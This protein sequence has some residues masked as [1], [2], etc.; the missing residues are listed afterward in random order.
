MSDQASGLVIEENAQAVEA[1]PLSSPVALAVS[2][3]VASPEQEQGDAVPH[4]RRRRRHKT[5]QHSAGDGAGASRV[6]ADVRPTVVTFS[7]ELSLWVAIDAN[8][9]EALLSWLRTHKKLLEGEPLYNEEG[10]TPLYRMLQEGFFEGAEYLVEAVAADL[11]TQENRDGSSAL[12]WLFDKSADKTD[13]SGNKK[14]NLLFQVWYAQDRFVL[15]DELTQKA[16]ECGLLAKAGEQAGA[17][18]P[19]PKA[20]KRQPAK[21]DESAADLLFAVDA[22]G[23]VLA[24]APAP[25]A[26]APRSDL[27]CVPDFYPAFM[28]DDVACLRQH[29][30]GVRDIIFK[31]LGTSC[32]HTTLE[33]KGYDAALLYAF[34]LGATE[35]FKYLLS[36]VRDLNRERTCV[37]GGSLIH[38]LLDANIIQLSLQTLAFKIPALINTDIS[39]PEFYSDPKQ[40]EMIHLYFADHRFD[41]HQRYVFKMGKIIDKSAA[42]VE[43]LTF[44]RGLALL[45][46]HNVAGSAVTKILFPLVEKGADWMGGLERFMESY[47]GS[48]WAV[49]ATAL[50]DQA[51]QEHIHTTPQI[52]SNLTLAKAISLQLYGTAEAMYKLSRGLIE[53][54]TEDKLALLPYLLE[55]YKKSR[56]AAFGWS[57]QFKDR[58]GHFIR[59]FLAWYPLDT[60]LPHLEE[61]SAKKLEEEVELFLASQ[62]KIDFIAAAEEASQGMQVGGSVTTLADQQEEGASL[63]FQALKND[64]VVSLQAHDELVKKVTLRAAPGALRA[65][66]LDLQGHDAALVYAFS[67][68]ATDCFKYLL[69]KIEDLNKERTYHRGGSLIHLLLDWAIIKLAWQTLAQSATASTAAEFYV[70]PKQRAMIKLLYEHPRFDAMW[71]YRFADGCYDSKGNASSSLCSTLERSLV[72]LLEARVTNEVLIE[73]IKIFICKADWKIDLLNFIFHH[74]QEDF[75]GSS[76]RASFCVD[77]VVES[78]ITQAPERYLD[79]DYNAISRLVQGRLYRSAQAILLLRG[80]A[81]DFPLEKKASCLRTLLGRYERL[82]NDPS[83]EVFKQELED[84][85]HF[86][87]LRWPAETW[88]ASLPAKQA[89]ELSTKIDSFI[90]PHSAEAVMDD[91]SAAASGW[92]ADIIR[93][94]PGTAEALGRQLEAAGFKCLGQPAIGADGRLLIPD[95]AGMSEEA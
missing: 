68:G 65:P 90:A 2:P 39:A 9:K 32:M 85:I 80:S 56:V 15:N 36:K 78:S 26:N 79:A 43:C 73:M 44:E 62:E 37:V 69:Y 3:A 81:I 10:Y 74:P 46:P 51:V 54:S 29:D 92:G 28:T 13:K 21:K 60:I 20:R 57:L 91:D 55:L 48:P 12:L 87:L 88:V 66:L 6:V 27:V 77:Q 72:L 23:K 76:L 5:S 89:G 45:L 4:K 52:V 58:V 63:V 82:K 11:V 53:I 8:D 25:A 14:A 42:S 22:R 83:L 31:A 40:I 64:V 38:F 35:C 7:P 18:A 16:Y 61:A 93:A 95:A 33:L 19:A 30:K 84:F 1:L 59:L 24:A 70:G 41:V 17:A 71:Q 67:L 94:A 86:F 75:L 34:S 47:L 50:I 49:Q